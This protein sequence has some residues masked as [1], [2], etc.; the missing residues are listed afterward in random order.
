MRPQIFKR[1]GQVI[2]NEVLNCVWVQSWEVE[3]KDYISCV[4]YRCFF[5][6]KYCCIPDTEALFHTGIMSEG[7]KGVELSIW[8]LFQQKQKQ[9]SFEISPQL[10]WNGL[11]QGSYFCVLC[12]WAYKNSAGLVFDE[13][14]VYRKMFL[15]QWKHCLNHSKRVTGNQTQTKDFVEYDPFLIK[16]A[17]NFNKKNKQDQIFHI[18]ERS[19]QSIR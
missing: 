2:S 8:Q 11:L 1:T 17:S 6:I 18:D 13:L 16:L 10:C 9:Y 7:E 19:W 3:P 15:I 14:I 4:L 12:C 5:R